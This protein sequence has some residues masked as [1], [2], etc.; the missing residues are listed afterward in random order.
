MNPNKKQVSFI[1]Q[2][3][4][5]LKLFD[6]IQKWD[7]KDGRFDLGFSFE[8]DENYCNKNF[9]LNYKGDSISYPEHY[10]HINLYKD[11]PKELVFCMMKNDPYDKYLDSRKKLTEFLIK[12]LKSKIQYGSNSFTGGYYYY[13]VNANKFISFLEIVHKKN[14]EGDEYKFCLSQESLDVKVSSFKDFIS[15]KLNER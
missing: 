7:C 3:Q 15:V 12:K 10:V 11:L 6:E 1:L 9:V 4:S 2:E 5:F 14:E 8:E 13:L